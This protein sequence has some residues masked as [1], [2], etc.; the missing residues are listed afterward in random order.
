V[1][2]KE[3]KLRR[4]EGRVSWRRH[5]C[6]TYGAGVAKR[7]GTRETEKQKVEEQSE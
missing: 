5:S 6:T 7:C 1:T 3:Q 2:T 4:I